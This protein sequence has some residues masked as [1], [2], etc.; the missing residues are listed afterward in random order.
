MKTKLARRSLSLLTLAL[1][2]TN[3]SAQEVATAASTAAAEGG[4]LG[5]EGRRAAGDGFGG[6]VPGD[7]WVFAWDSFVHALLLCGMGHSG[8][9]LTAR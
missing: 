7:E 9:C 1:A 8:T 5:H 6:G 3:L 2:A 4:G